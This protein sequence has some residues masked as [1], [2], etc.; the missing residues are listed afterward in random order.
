MRAALNAFTPVASVGFFA[1]LPSLPAR[2]LDFAFFT[3][4]KG[5]SLTSDGRKQQTTNHT[6]TPGTTGSS[7]AG[8]A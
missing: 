8:P 6:K 1:A 4:V 2:A 5:M 7:L 3:I